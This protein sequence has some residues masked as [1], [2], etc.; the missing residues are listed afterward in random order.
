M[1]KE[2]GQT[3]WQGAHSGIPS[4]LGCCPA[5]DWGER[6]HERLFEDPSVGL[7][8]LHLL[9][10]GDKLP[11]PSTPCILIKP[12]LLLL[13]SL[14]IFPSSTLSMANSYSSFKAQIKQI[15]PVISSP[16][17]LNKVNPP[18]SVPPQ[19]FAWI[20]RAHFIRQLFV[21]HLLYAHLYHL[22]AEMVKNLP[23]MQETR[24]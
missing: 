12:P 16:C 6:S 20:F 3:P 2:Q 1:C 13:F 10:P 19:S 21:E 4:T 7:A 22:V 5:W 15:L 23:A 18:F 24:V 17:L 14:P 8:P 9:Q 11:I